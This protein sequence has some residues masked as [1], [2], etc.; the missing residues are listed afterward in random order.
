MATYWSICNDSKLVDLLHTGQVQVGACSCNWR[1]DDASKH[2][3]CVQLMDL[4]GISMRRVDRGHFSDMTVE[5]AT[6]SASCARLRTNDILA[7]IAEDFKP[8][9]YSRV[10]LD[11]LWSYFST[12]VLLPIHQQGVVS[13]DWRQH[14]ISIICKRAFTPDVQ[15]RHTFWVNAN[16]MAT[17]F[18][19]PAR[20]RM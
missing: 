7:W 12:W 17:K 3:L 6:M 8:W 2:W 5:V 16:V 20:F 9:T 11:L 4:Q 10:A 14:R 15:E 18:V 1:K 13:R 19:Y